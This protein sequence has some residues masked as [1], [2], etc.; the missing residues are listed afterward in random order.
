M[1][2]T[3]IGRMTVRISSMTRSIAGGSLAAVLAIGLA[4][5]VGAQPPPGGFGPGPGPG[6]PGPGAIVGGALLGLGAA[7]LVGAA[8][9]RPP[10]PPPPVYVAPPP[11]PTYVAPYGY[12]YSA[13]YPN[14]YAPA[15]PAYYGR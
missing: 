6:G 1:D 5:P 9:T 4:G 12:P 15:P 7:A 13:P 2:D 10:P 11:Q 14:S 3:Q 8:L